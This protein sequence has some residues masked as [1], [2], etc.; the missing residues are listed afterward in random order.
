M[1]FHEKQDTFQPTKH[2]GRVHVYTG[3][4]KG[5]T[6]AALGLSM[7]ALGHGFSVL[8]VQF[9]KHHRDLGEFKLQTQ[10]REHIPQFEIVQF[11]QPGVIDLSQ[12]SSVD[13]FYA[14]QG[15]DYARAAVQRDGTRPDLVVLDEV[16]VLVHYG[17]VPERFL[18]DFL[19]NKPQNTEMVLTGRY[20]PPSIVEYADLITEMTPVKHYY[21][22]AF[23]ARQG[24][25]Y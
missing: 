2:W 11:G 16:N 3:E 7:R 1:I 8:F 17:I 22:D 19:A 20:A 5:K 25:E 21:H 24:I 18:L 15:I 12:P 9:L 4:G 13:V 6:T 14:K 10:L 23:Q